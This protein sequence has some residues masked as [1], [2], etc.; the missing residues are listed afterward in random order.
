[1][2]FF[3]V[4]TGGYQVYDEVIDK[5]WQLSYCH[6]KPIRHKIQIQVI[7]KNKE[8]FHFLR[9]AYF[10]LPKPQYAILNVWQV[11]TMDSKQV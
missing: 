11:T 8:L 3:Y 4:L 1:M 6:S 7:F 2:L 9:M 10:Y 5:S